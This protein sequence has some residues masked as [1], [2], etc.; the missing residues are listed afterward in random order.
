MTA[1]KAGSRVKV[2]ERELTADDAK[3][4]L[5]YSYFGGLMGTVDRLYD[6]DSVC[7]DIDIDSLT[8]EMRARHLSVQEAERKRW[9]ENLSDELRN[10][11]NAEQKQLKMNYRILVAQKDLEPSNSDKP[12]AKAAPEIAKREAAP[13]EESKKGAGDAP[14]PS[15]NARAPR[16]SPAQA[17]GEPDA[18]ADEPSPKRLSE[19]D[20]AAAEEEFLR[21]RQSEA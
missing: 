20:L 17:S 11:L 10:R 3:T 14:A 5:Y 12:A 1:P 2:V 8:E 4:G 6:D 13:V 21:S 15:H 19:A 9:L 18:P 7:V 16:G